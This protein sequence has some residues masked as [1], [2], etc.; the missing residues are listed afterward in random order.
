MYSPTPDIPLIDRYWQSYA[1]PPAS[2][3]S[4]PSSLFS[5]H[6]SFCIQDIRPHVYI[7]EKGS[8]VFPCAAETYNIYHSL[9]KRREEKS[10]DIPFSCASVMGSGA[11]Q[12]PLSFAPSSN[13]VCNTISLIKSDTHRPSQRERDLVIGDLPCYIKHNSHQANSFPFL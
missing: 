13:T 11:L 5:L 6:H 3:S 9:Q 10:K 2:L 1:Q 12:S 8:I 4:P 7:T